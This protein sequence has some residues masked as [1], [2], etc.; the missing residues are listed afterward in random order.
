MTE[1]EVAKIIV[2]V[3][4]QSDSKQKRHHAKA[5]R[6][7]DSV[8]TYDECSCAFASFGNSKKLI[9]CGFAPLRDPRNGIRYD[10]KRSR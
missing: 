10:G 3:A 8:E 6:R 5:Q 7:K 9:L 2:D 1:N 4:Y